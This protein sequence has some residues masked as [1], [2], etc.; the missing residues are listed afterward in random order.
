MVL[1]LSFQVSCFW[2]RRSFVTHIAKPALCLSTEPPAF[3]DYSKGEAYNENKPSRTARF[4]RH[5]TRSSSHPPIRTETQPELP[6]PPAAETRSPAGPAAAEMVAKPVPAPQINGYG[7]PP[8]APK[9]APPVV[10]Q[11]QPPPSASASSAPFGGVAL[12]GM[13]HRPFEGQAATERSAS[14]APPPSSS[15]N[16]PTVRPPSAFNRPTSAAAMRSP[17]PTGPAAFRQSADQNAEEDDPVARSLAELRRDPPPAGSI[18]RG[19]SARRPESTHPASRNSVQMPPRSPAPPFIADG[20]KPDNRMSYQGQPSGRGSV[21]TSLVPPAA[22]HTAAALAQ[23]LADHEKRSS[24]SYNQ[25]GP[26]QDYNAAANDIVGQHPASRPTT[27]SGQSAPRTP[28]PVFMQAPTQAPSHID[29]VLGQYHQAF[30]GERASRG[31]SRAGSISSRH[32]R[33]H[34]VG[35]VAPPAAAQPRSPSPAAREGFVGIGS[36]NVAARA[37]S[38]LPGARPTSTGANG[39]QPP[40]PAGVASVAPLATSRSQQ[41]HAVQPPQ[42]ARPASIHTG[43]QPQPQATG[44][45]PG[46]QPA[47]VPPQSTRYSTY[48]GSPAPQVAPLSVSHRSSTSQ[49]ASMPSATGQHVQPVQY[50]ASPQPAMYPAYAAPPPPATVTSPVGYDQYGRP[51]GQ[52]YGMAPQAYGQPLIPPVAAPGQPTPAQQY[53]AT[54]A[55]GPSPQPNGQYRP[56]VSTAPAAPVA[57]TGP[58][59]PPAPQANQYARTA[60]PAPAAQPAYYQPQQQQQQQPQP[61]APVP[62]TAYARAA[63][64]AVAVQQQAPVQRSPSPVPPQAPVDAPPTGQYSTTGQ[65]ILFCEWEFP[66]VSRSLGLWTTER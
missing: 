58:Y 17:P 54:V 16:P 33:A 63:S 53:A 52:A 44:Q 3:V 28:S 9:P 36:G 38:P 18:R 40:Y 42:Q 47:G 7:P 4:T 62:Q 26:A 60:S 45:I 23:S 43:Q 66:R 8:V 1:A 34:S 31:P 25:G 41:G 51:Y 29:D 56:P 65:P 35:N 59:Q 32:S 64:P 10:Q 20:Q 6:T 13:A 50:S 39:V 14:P 55:V 61:Q 22:G 49:Y 21:D 48:S 24:R 19:P 11:Q 12:P 15:Y 57:A 5:T 2:F 46:L 27:P 37:S 30:P